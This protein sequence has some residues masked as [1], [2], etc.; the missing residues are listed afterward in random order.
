VVV[1]EVAN[2]SLAQRAGLVRGDV[3]TSVDKKAVHSPSDFAKLV[4]KD[5]KD[6]VLRVFRGGLSTYVVLK[7]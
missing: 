5:A 7:R 3:I 4:R 6:V 2:G 1:G